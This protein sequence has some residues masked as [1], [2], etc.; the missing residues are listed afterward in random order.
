MGAVLA[1]LEQAEGEIQTLRNRSH[2]H[3]QRITTWGNLTGAVRS[4]EKRVRALENRQNWIAG[5]CAAGGGLIGA[6]IMKVLG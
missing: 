4:V 1:R 5:A 3:A 2:D 6:M